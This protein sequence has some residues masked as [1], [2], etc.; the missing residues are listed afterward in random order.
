MLHL[1]KRIKRAVIAVFP[2][3]LSSFQ[4][5]EFLIKKK[6]EKSQIQKDINMQ[7]SIKACGS[8]FSGSF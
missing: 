7:V 3:A 2:L 8:N 6:K 4:M 1:S 5:F